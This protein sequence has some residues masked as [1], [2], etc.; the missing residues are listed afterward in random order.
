MCKYTYV[1]MHKY[2]HVY[3]Y[4]GYVYV[5]IYVYV[6]TCMC[7]SVGVSVHVRTHLCEDFLSYA[8]I[9]ADKRLTLDLSS[10]LYLFF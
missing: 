9:C 10:F 7:V 8:G 6:Y 2:M 4:V 3:V 5:Y 1:C